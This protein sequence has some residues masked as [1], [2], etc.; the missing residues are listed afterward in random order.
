MSDVAQRFLVGADSGNASVLGTVL[1]TS[2]GERITSPKVA[3]AKGPGVP[4]GG[5]LSLSDTAQIASTAAL[6]ALGLVLEDVS[7]AGDGVTSAILGGIAQV[8]GR[9]ADLS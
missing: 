9:A 4:E 3:R 7:G 1:R 6:E 2:H 5:Q 8:T